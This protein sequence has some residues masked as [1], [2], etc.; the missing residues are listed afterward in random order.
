MTTPTA[1]WQSTIDPTRKSQTIS[2]AVFQLDCTPGGTA[3]FSELGAI[4]SEVESKEYMEVGKQGPEYGR[5]I[6]QAKP[7]TVTLK[8]SMSTGLDTTWI[9]TWHMQAR[10][11]G[12][13]AFRTA[14]LKFFTPTQGMQQAVKVY[15]LFNAFPTKVEIAGIK[16]GAT[17]V[18]LQTVTLQCDEIIEDP[19]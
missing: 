10:M 7:P 6:G 13:L 18:V 9:W 3:M 11:G 2:A 19:K 17:D 8:R 14:Y 1:G 5:F 16:A 4:A 15:G 12:S